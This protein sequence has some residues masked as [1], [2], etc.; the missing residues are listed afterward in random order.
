MEF[1]KMRDK[2]IANFEEMTKDVNHL[3]TVAVDKD[4]LW[5]TYLDSY[6][7]GTNE[8]YRKRRTNDCSSCRQF[9]RS[10]GNV[11]MIKDNKVTTI[12]DFDTESATYQPVMDALA[13]FV[14]AHPVQD[15]F[16]TDYTKICN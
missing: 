13:A 2:L 15:V 5:N 14:K 8:I 10:I 6:P 7:R 11:V 4:E 16:V 12:W 3:Y 1:K 9:V